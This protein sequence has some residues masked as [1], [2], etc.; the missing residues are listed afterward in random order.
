MCMFLSSPPLSFSDQSAFLSLYS[1][2]AFF[3]WILT[4]IV[5]SLSLSSWR[6]TPAFLRSS[7]NRYS[8][9]TEIPPNKDIILR[10]RIYFSLARSCLRAYHY[11]YERLPPRLIRKQIECRPRPTKLRAQIH[12]LSRKK[13]MFH[14][15]YGLVKSPALYAGS[16]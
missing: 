13:R 6:E 4:K 15:I 1:Y 7:G 11:L 9:R 12:D 10:D 16:Y 3:S 5:T 14:A 2:P 8:H